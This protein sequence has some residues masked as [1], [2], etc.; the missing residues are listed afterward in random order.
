MAKFEGHILQ[1]TKYVSTK[2]ENFADV[3]ML[4]GIVGGGGVQVDIACIKS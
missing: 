1:I 2:S 3:P 4:G